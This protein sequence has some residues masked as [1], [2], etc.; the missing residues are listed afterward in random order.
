MAIRRPTPDPEGLR[1][2]R[3]P[4][5][6]RARAGRIT[7]RA[8]HLGRASAWPLGWYRLRLV[9]PH[10]DP[11][12]G[13]AYGASTFAVVAS[14]TTLPT[15]PSWSTPG[16]VGW[17]PKSSV[18][19]ALGGADFVLRGLIDEGTARLSLTDPLDATV[20]AQN[21]RRNLEFDRHW[22][23][24]PRYADPVR[25]HEYVLAFP[26]GAVT[27]EELAGVTAAV[28]VLYP[29][30]TWYEGPVNEPDFTMAPEKCVA[31]MAAFAAAV[32]AGN[33]NAKVLGPG[34]VSINH[35][36]LPYG[37]RTSPREVAITSTA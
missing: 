21:W 8:I 10:V 29:M 25:P 9:G 14:S 36:T 19:G 34:L 13:N 7:R 18:K 5:H 24:N 2:A 27:P 30:V 37:R 12:Y 22:W 31:D 32:K 28:Q 16:N 17:S 26:N 20:Q 33:P 35:G 1:G 6:R 11:L 3:R 4:R 15:V 23:T